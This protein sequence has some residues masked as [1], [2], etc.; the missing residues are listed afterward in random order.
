MAKT[1]QFRRGT[2]A[3]LSSVTGAVGE[4]FVDTTKDT[5]VVMDGSTAGGV[6][7]Q[8]EICYT[9][10]TGSHIIIGNPDSIAC[11]AL[12]LMGNYITSQ[13]THVFYGD[14]SFSANVNK[15]VLGE[16]YPLA[17]EA[18]VE[19]TTVLAQ[20]AFDYANTITTS[21]DQWVRNQANAAFSGAN[22]AQIHAQA[23]FNAANTGGGASTGDFT[24]SANT[25]TLPDFTDGVLN[26]SGNVSTLNE[27]TL[28]LT[29][30]TFSATWIISHLHDSLSERVVISR[31]TSETTESTGVVPDFANNFPAGETLTVV[32]DGTTHTVV[33]PQ[34][35]TYTN[36]S[37][38]FGGR[39]H[40]YESI[41]DDNGW[42]GPGGPTYFTNYD[43]MNSD[44][45]GATAS[46]GSIVQTD[47]SYTFSQ[48][49]ELISDSALIGEVLIAT[50]IITP[51]AYDS[52]GVATTGTL[53][54]N[55]NLDVTGSIPGLLR[56]DTSIVP[57]DNDSDVQALIS[58]GGL[59]QA[60]KKY[61]I[62]VSTGVGDPEK[63]IVLPD[64]TTLTKGDSVEIFYFDR[65]DTTDLIV[66]P[67]D[68]LN[69]GFIRPAYVT[70]TD[71]QSP[72]NVGGYEEVGSARVWR[73]L[74]RGMKATFILDV[75]DN[76]GTNQYNWVV[77]Y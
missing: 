72:P 42:P 32:I 52:Y 14:A 46:Y 3:E 53:T 40:V 25:I 10:N 57:P 11:T 55:G 75:Y 49:G 64:P 66:H 67:Y 6:P 60:N 38:G 71:N 56:Y 59:L 63:G 48:T 70:F 77:V 31:R 13:N 61:Y 28:S 74:A 69:H 23:A 73:F 54:V 50:D 33:L 21:T 45:K 4:L 37:D 36:I 5:V 2:T 44:V 1:L 7:L 17:T 24:F 68:D 19:T 12:D 47:F 18:Y 16:S 43:F 35:F 65:T 51:I 39:I 8:K 41:I 76:N 26:V 62:G 58:A 27:V 9:A 34:A 30:D 15:M 20:A 29:S 22:T